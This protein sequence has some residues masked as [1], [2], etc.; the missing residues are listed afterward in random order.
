MR[1]MP[2]ISAALFSVIQVTQLHLPEIDTG[3]VKKIEIYIC[4]LF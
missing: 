1:N 3:L 2:L 4:L